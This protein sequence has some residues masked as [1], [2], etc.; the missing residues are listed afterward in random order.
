[1]VL[2]GIANGPSRTRGVAR[3]FPRG[4]RGF[5]LCQNEGTQQIPMSFSPPVLGCLLKKM[6]YKGEWGHGHPRIPL[7]TP[8]KT[9]GLA[10]FSGFAVS[11]FKR[12]C[13]SRSLNFLQGWTCRAGIKNTLKCQGC[14]WRRNMSGPAEK[15]S[16]LA[17]SQSLT[18]TLHHKGGKALKRIKADHWFEPFSI[19][20]P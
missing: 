5:A 14:N 15:N 20:F 8:L 3:I 6:D 13:T 10:K 2:K 16:S 12:W 1:M 17:F 7:A 19:H 9:T 18:F 4:G 11:L